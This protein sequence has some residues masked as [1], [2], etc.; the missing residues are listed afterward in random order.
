MAKQSESSGKQSNKRFLSHPNF[1]LTSLFTKTLKPAAALAPSHPNSAGKIVPSFS[2]A[3][4]LQSRFGGGG[5]AFWVWWWC[6]RV[7]VVV[8]RSGWCGGGVVLSPAPFSLFHEEGLRRRQFLAGGNVGK[9]G[10]V[11]LSLR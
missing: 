1:S 11:S 3:G 10:G 6:G 8:V 9:T 7:D 2:A 5:G 4:L